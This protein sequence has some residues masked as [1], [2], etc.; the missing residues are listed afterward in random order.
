MEQCEYGQGPVDQ[1]DQRHRKRIWFV[2]TEPGLKDLMRRCGRDHEHAPL[3]GRRPGATATRCAEAAT[4]PWELVHRMAHLLVQ[5]ALQR[6]A[7]LPRSPTHPT[8]GGKHC[9][10]RAVHRSRLWTVG[11]GA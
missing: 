5:A 4:Y 11:P 1:D 7:V 9:K 6:G 10:T 2:T 8:R 3:K